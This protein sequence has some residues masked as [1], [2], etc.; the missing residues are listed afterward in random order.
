MGVAEAAAPAGL[1]SAVPTFA[2][3]VSIVVSVGADEQVRWVDA[4]RVVAVMTD[5]QAVRDGLS[6]MR[7]PG[8]TVGT[9]GVAPW[10]LVLDLA[11]AIAIESP[12]PLPALVVTEL[13]G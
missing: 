7:L 8:D 11:V 3:L 6:M 1:A 9:E 2:D 13:V 10:R 5:L 4:G 12:L